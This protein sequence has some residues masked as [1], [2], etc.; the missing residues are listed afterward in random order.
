MWREKG[1][2]AFPASDSPNPKA[3]RN[4]KRKPRRSKRKN[5][6]PSKLIAQCRRAVL[7]PCLSPSFKTTR[8]RT[9]MDVVELATKIIQEASS[10]A[11]ASFPMYLPCLPTAPISHTVP[12]PE[13]AS[14]HSHHHHVA[15]L[16]PLSLIPLS[17]I[18]SQSS[19]REGRF[20]GL[21]TS[22]LKMP[23][24]LCFP[25]C[26]SSKSCQMSNL[27]KKTVRPEARR[28]ET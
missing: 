2:G 7:T 21:P 17:I 13:S 4:K 14:G 23:C 22:P 3:D 10:E 18:K 19:F 20:F 5:Q 25:A 28:K 27:T 16:A 12:K 26:H 6:D 9:T 15:T 24:R 8:R 1:P 11:R